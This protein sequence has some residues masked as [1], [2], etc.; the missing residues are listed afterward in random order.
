MPISDLPHNIYFLGKLTLH[1]CIYTFSFENFNSHFLTAVCT[2]IPGFVDKIFRLTTNCTKHIY[3]REALKK[4]ISSDLQI[5]IW[6]RCNFMLKL[7]MSRINFPY[8]S[9]I[10]WYFHPIK[11]TFSC[12]IEFPH[13]RRGFTIWPNP[14]LKRE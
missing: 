2:F 14:I 12:Y 8:I 5:P 13:R 6:T 1:I 7:Q 4:K 9:P 11:L 3:I 10:C